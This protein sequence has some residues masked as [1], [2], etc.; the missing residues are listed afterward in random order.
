MKFYDIP[1][2]SDEWNELRKGKFTASNF[3]DLLAGKTTQAYEKAIYRVVFERLTGQCVEDNYQSSYMKRG[4]ELE[5]QA[6]EIYSLHTFNK[7]SNGGFFEF[8]DWIGGSPDGLIGEDGLLEVKCP[9]YNTIINYLLKRELPTEY[10]YQVH[11][12]MLISGRAWVDFCAFHPALKEPLILRTER[13]EKVLT[14]L[15]DFLDHAVN[16]A[17]SLIKKLKKK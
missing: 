10:F 9:A 14:D 17:K 5:S 1:Q 7:V 12:Q 4:V 16:T 13:D 8:S 3:K 11:G 15:R 2:R 6:I